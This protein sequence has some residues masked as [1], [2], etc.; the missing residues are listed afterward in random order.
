LARRG[1][2]RPAPVLARL[3]YDRTRLGALHARLE[4]VSYQAVLARGFALVMR[5]EDGALLGRAADVPAGAR[6]TLAFAD[7]QV[8]ATADGAA[9]ARPAS[10]RKPGDPP[11]QAA[12][13]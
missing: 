3:R 10:R 6:L 5:E 13:L 9:G 7:G 1:G 2:L 4:A 8:A 12:L 11:A